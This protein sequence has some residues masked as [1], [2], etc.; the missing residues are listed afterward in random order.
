MKNVSGLVEVL[1]LGRSNLE[2]AVNAASQAGRG[3]HLG[4]A[5]CSLHTAD[6]T[7]ARWVYRHSV[8]C[9][10]Q[11]PSRCE[12]ALRRAPSTT[13]RPPD[14]ATLGYS[15][16][17]RAACRQNGARVRH[18]AS[19][20]VGTRRPREPI[21]GVGPTARRRAAGVVATAGPLAGVDASRGRPRRARCARGARGVVLGRRGVGG[22]RPS[23]SADPVTRRPRR[24]DRRVQR[25]PPGCHRGAGAARLRIC[26]GIRAACMDATGR[27]G[28]RR[29]RPQGGSGQH[30]L[31]LSGVGF[32]RSATDATGP[33]T[34]GVRDGHDR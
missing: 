7:M 27:R 32:R 5:S 2:Q 33:R 16:G 19:P 22:G 6:W 11:H 13:G 4:R 15:P 31:G 23:C 14:T 17:T 29:V 18:T 1:Q 12:T 25:R 26:G 28:Q 3:E 21:R 20:P 24:C 34:V 8:T 30:R 9:T 10:G